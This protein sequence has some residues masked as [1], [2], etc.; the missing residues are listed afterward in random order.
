M[1]FFFVIHRDEKQ[2]KREQVSLQ[3]DAENANEKKELKTT[4]INVIPLLGCCF[5][6]SRPV[7][8]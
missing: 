5:P 7:Y 1:F 8:L 6:L 2:T 3:A 4:R